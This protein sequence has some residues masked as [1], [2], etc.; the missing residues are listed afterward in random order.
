MA[1]LTQRP[2][3]R[4]REYETIYILRGDVDPDT[5]EKVAGRVKWKFDARIDGIVQGWPTAFRT[6]RGLEMGFKADGDFEGVIRQYL[7]DEQVTP[8]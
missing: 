2:T 8:K 5:A 1:A 3:N 4:V 7:E 6:P